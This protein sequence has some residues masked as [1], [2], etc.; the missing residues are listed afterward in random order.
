MKKSLKYKLSGEGTWLYIKSST[1]G[2]TKRLFF[3]VDA[4]FFNLLLFQ[5]K[6]NAT[7]TA[8]AA[9]AASASSTPNSTEFNVSTYVYILD[10]VHFFL[11]VIFSSPRTINLCRNKSSFTFWKKNF[12]KVSDKFLGQLLVLPAAKLKTACTKLVFVPRSLWSNLEQNQ[13]IFL[14]GIS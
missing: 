1:F 6:K 2:A 13:N 7:A 8:T 4:A 10:V 14:K 11:V 9:A 3:W 12:N 5:S